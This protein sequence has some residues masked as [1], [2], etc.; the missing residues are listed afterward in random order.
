M[1][2]CEI[3]G[4]RDWGKIDEHLA[5]NAVLRALDY[6]VN[7]FDTADVYGLGRS[8]QELSRILGVRRHDVVIITK[9]GVRWAEN[10][11][12]ERA[13]T[14]YD[15]S[16]EY[17]VRSIENSLRRLRIECIPLYL[18]HWPDPNTPIDMTL[19]ALVRC[20]EAG[21]IRYF[22]LSN[23]PGVKVMEANRICKLGA[24]EILYNLVNRECETDV[25]PIAQ[26][27]GLGVLA[28]G[29]LAQGLLTGKYTRT[30]V[31][32]QTD[33]RHRLWHFSPEAWPVNQRLLK[34]LS[35][36][37][38]SYGKTLAQIA[39]RWVLDQ[40]GVTAAIVGAKSP[41]QVD[42]N[43]GALHWSLSEDERQFLANDHI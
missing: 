37:A 32:D 25:L 43:V 24:I 30:S 2:G 21:K 22:G 17:V 7:T 23:F 31:F 38:A 6:G 36:V 28:Y 27:L 3:L 10:P 39:I 13:K 42:A 15:S 5:S 19:D 29:A 20:Q 33:R 9:C 14:W 35:R 18:V 11:A 40:P 1:L 12:G 26:A 34:R 16:P 41:E 4:G 8:E